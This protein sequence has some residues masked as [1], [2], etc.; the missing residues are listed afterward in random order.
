M[1]DATPP[2]SDRAADATLRRCRPK[3]ALSERSE[4]NGAGVVQTREATWGI[5]YVW[6]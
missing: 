6:L 4:S 5:P 2:A 3:P 1:S